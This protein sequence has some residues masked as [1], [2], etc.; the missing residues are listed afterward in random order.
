LSNNPNDLFA[1]FQQAQCYIDIAANNFELEAEQSAVEPDF[2]KGFDLAKMFAIRDKS[3]DSDWELFVEACVLGRAC[4]D[5]WGNA[6]ESQKFDREAKVFLDGLPRRF[7]TV[8]PD[9]LDLQRDLVQ[10]K[11]GAQN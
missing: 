4:Y 6:Q 5:R 11:V 8:D 10:D 2:K 1:R 3:D 7:P 9:W